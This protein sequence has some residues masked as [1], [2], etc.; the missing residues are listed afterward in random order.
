MKPLKYAI[1]AVIC[2]VGMYA[3]ASAA[4]YNHQ[5]GE[6]LQQTISETKY[7]DLFHGYICERLRKG[8]GD[9]VLSNLKVHKNK[10]VAK[11]DI[12]F[13]VFQKNK[14]VPMG[15]VRLSVIV[16][17][18][19]ISRNEVT[20]SAWVDVFESVVCATR[21]LNKGEIIH[22]EDI[23]LARKNIS[24]MSSKVL[25]DQN[26]AVGLA[27]KNSI[28]ENSCLKEYMLERI[29]IF[30]KGDMV[31][32]LAEM[33]GLRVTAPGIALERGYVGDL[34]RVENSMSGK[35]IYA[36]VID[37]SIVQVNF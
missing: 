6:A 32:I 24:R 33:D 5:A 25:T 18:D 10:P 23:Y 34:I 7:N 3:S 1:M 31:M 28:K 26:M 19:G 12:E 21:T 2:S 15:Y 35:R 9:I 11:G 8:A 16:R 13:E 20:L 17:V 14:G 36:R 27:L 4:T 37:D 30:K 29:P 22:P